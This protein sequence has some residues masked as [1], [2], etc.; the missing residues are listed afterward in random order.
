MPQGLHHQV[1]IDGVEITLDVEV[2]GK[3]MVE[4]VPLTVNFTPN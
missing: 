3:V 2:Y 4:T 1:V